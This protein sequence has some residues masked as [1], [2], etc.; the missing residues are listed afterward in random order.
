MSGETFQNVLEWNE[1]ESH[2]QR[3]DGDIAAEQN[4]H[5]GDVSRL[6]GTST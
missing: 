2:E 6:A 4:D 1:L 3:E 5:H